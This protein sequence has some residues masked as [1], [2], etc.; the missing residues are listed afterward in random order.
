MRP[1]D[2]IPQVRA[3]MALEKLADAGPEALRLFEAGEFDAAWLEVR[4]A[5]DATNTLMQL[6]REARSDIGT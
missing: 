1:L 3:K 6:R 5:R 2:H 4:R